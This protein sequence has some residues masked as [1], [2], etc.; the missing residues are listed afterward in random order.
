[1]RKSFFESYSRD[2]H[3]KIV[4]MGTTFTDMEEHPERLFT[5]HGYT[6]VAMTSVPLYAVERAN[7]GI[8]RLAVRYFMRTLRDGYVIAVFRR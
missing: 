6:Q 3:E 5:E 2:L 7:L 4:G 8:P 1:M